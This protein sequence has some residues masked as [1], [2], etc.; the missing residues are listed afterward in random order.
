MLLILVDSRPE[1]YLGV[2]VSISDTESDTACPTFLYRSQ[3]RALG[4]EGRIQSTSTVLHSSP[5][6][7][8]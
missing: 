1:I 5:L 6:Y 8:T 2:Q 3:V 4:V 7:Y